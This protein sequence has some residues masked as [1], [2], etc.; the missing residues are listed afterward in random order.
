MV[1]FNVLFEVQ[2]RGHSEVLRQVLT[3]LPFIKF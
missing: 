2:C 1:P 3:S